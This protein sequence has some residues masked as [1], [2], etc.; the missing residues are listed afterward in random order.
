MPQVCIYFGETGVTAESE[1]PA[2]LAEFVTVISKDLGLPRDWRDS[3]YAVG[4]SWDQRIS[5]NCTIQLYSLLWVKVHYQGRKLKIRC[6]PGTTVQQA[7]TISASKLELPRGW[8][9][10]VKFDQG[11]TLETELH[12]DR[13]VFVRPA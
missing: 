7:L 11:L 10:L 6:I 5:T 13:D 1:G 8:A 9:E 12:E 2:A 3:V 4:Y